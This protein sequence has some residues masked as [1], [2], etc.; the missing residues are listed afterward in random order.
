MGLGCWAAVNAHS[1]GISQSEHAP[2][3]APR[4][5]YLQMST[6]TR[7]WSWSVAITVLN[8]HVVASSTSE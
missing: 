8:P 5:L 4:E 3:P 6:V 7:A 2:P 1:I